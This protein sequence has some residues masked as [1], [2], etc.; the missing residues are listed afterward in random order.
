MPDI[1]VQEFREQ[2]A[3]TRY[4]FTDKS[5]LRT[6]DGKDLPP[7]LFLDA[8][9]YPVG[10]SQP[11][12]IAKIVVVP[13]TATFTLAT[14]TGGALATATLDLVNPEEILPFEDTAGRPAGVMVVNADRA[15]DL[16]GFVPGTYILG[17]AAASLA[18]ACVI[19]TPAAGVQGIRLPDGS[20][21]TGDI[22]LV[23]GDGVVLRLS[24]DLPNAIR[25]DV[26][27][28]SLFRRKLCVPE[29]L[30]TTPRFV[31][32]INGCAPDAYGN[33]NLLVGAHRHDAPVLRILPGNGGLI[34]TAA[35]K[36]TPGVS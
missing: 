30:F 4:P 35:R 6:A 29:E 10:N 13:R 17:A 15:V 36:A 26:V 8:S 21:L 16:A 33:Y 2:L 25:V 23:G 24:E 22:W 5:T 7:D 1:F 20:L 19:P 18:A 28:D 31:K 3:P 11:L 14:P 12:H 32:T 9:L 34:I 27:G